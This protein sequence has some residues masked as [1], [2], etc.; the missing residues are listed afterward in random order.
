MRGG[1]SG[2]HWRSHAINEHAEHPLG[3]VKAEC[4]H[5]LM[6]VTALREKP[7]GKPCQARAALRFDR[8]MT[9]IPERI[10]PPRGGDGEL[11]GGGPN[12]QAWVTD[13]GDRGHRR[14]MSSS[15]QIGPCAERDAQISSP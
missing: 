13:V 9:K 7:F 1:L 10:R 5:L 4:G 8:A 3:V 2:R 12:P 6:M 11:D 15:A 14:M